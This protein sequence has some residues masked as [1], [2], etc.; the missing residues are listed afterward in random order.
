MSKSVTIAARVDADLDSKLERLASATGRSKSWHIN[1][2]LQ[3]YAANGATRQLPFPGE[4]GSVAWHKRAGH[5]ERVT[6]PG[7]G[8]VKRARRQLLAMKRRN[9]P[10]LGPLVKDLRTGV[11]ERGRDHVAV[12]DCHERP[13]D[14]FI[15]SITYSPDR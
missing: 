3:S 11:G 2:A 8:R 4:T 7:V 5:F 6:L 13:L 1:E 15:I 9:R 10:A 12:Q 14:A